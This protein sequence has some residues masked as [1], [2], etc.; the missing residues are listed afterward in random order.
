MLGDKERERGSV[1]CV[2]RAAL[3]GC[4]CFGNF[5]GAFL[6][7]GASPVISDSVELVMVVMAV[8]VRS[9]E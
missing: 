6:G 7:L 4:F 5:T 1:S 9:K 3:A 2:C 8:Q